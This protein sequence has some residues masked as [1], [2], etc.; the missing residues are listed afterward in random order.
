[1]GFGLVEDPHAA[2][3]W[4]AVAPEGSAPGLRPNYDGVYYA[5]YVLDPAGNNI[6]AAIRRK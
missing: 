5:A 2:D 6:E 1:M 3:W 4:V